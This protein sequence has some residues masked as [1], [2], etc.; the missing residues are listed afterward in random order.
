VLE[1]HHL[2]PQALQSHHQRA[3]QAPLPRWT[4]GP[5]LGLP[6]EPTGPAQRV[7]QALGPEHLLIRVRTSRE[8]P[9]DEQARWRISD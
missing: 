3:A 8:Y 1:H 5:Q 9:T 4:P 2:S 7:E 6:F